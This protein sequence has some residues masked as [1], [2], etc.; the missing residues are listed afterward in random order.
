MIDFHCCHSIKSAYFKIR[1]LLNVVF[2]PFFQVTGV[3]S[4]TG[5][6]TDVNDAALAVLS[7]LAWVISR[8]SN[9]INK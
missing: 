8:T 1:E 6:P 7:D 3:R 5:F 2:G 4:H 9:Q